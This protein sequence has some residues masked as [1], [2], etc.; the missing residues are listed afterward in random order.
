MRHVCRVAVIVYYDK[1]AVLLRGLCD[2]WLYM[3]YAAVAIG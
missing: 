3:C 2:L 1:E